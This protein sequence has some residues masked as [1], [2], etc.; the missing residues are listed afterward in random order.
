VAHYSGVCG[1]FLVFFRMVL[2]GKVATHWLGLCLLTCWGFRGSLVEILMS[3]DSLMGSVWY[4]LSKLF[5]YCI[6]N[7]LARAILYCIVH[8]K[9]KSSFSRFPSGM[10]L[11][12]LSLAGNY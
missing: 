3:N 4:L 8:C 11:T 5:L 1:T 10:S 12:K 6:G 9:N 2:V 7:V